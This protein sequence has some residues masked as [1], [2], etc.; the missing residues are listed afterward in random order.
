[1]E[2]I[3]IPKVKIAEE[4]GNTAVFVIEPFYPGYGTTVGNSLRRVLLT[5]L[6]GV[7]VTAVKISGVDHEFTTIEGVKEDVVEIMLNLKHL[8]FVMH[9]EGPVTVQLKATKSGSVTGKDITLP[10]SVE[11]VNPDRHIATLGSGKSFEAEIRVE[12]GRGYLPSEEIDDKGFSIGMIA[13]D[14]AFS[15]VQRCSFKV[16]NTRVGERVDYDKLTLELETDGTIAPADALSSASDILIEQFGSLKG[17]GSPEPELVDAELANEADDADMA[18]A[19]EKKGS[20]KDFSVEEINLS[21]RTTNALTQN[22][23]KKVK[24]ILKTG[25]EGLLEMKGVGERAVTEIADKLEELKID[26]K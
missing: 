8:R 16:E 14:A 12:T 1:M 11:L 18:D 2:A 5:S 20:P 9:E 19:T 21:I 4:D 17:G 23:I 24:D 3:N 25:R 7:A 10:S 26:F 22:G 15:P 13:V 6:P